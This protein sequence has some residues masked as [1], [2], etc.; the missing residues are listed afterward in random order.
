MK[1]KTILLIT[2]TAM[3]AATTRAQ[4]RWVK[5]DHDFGAFSEDIGAVD[6]VFEMVNDSPKAV[7]ILD[8]RATCGCTQPEIPRGD[9]AP[10]DTARIKVTYLASGRPGRFNK[11]IYVRTSDNPSEQK[12]LTVSGTVIGASATLASRFPVTA[13][14]LRLRTTTIAFGDVVRGKQKT[15]FV[16]GYNQSTDTLEPAVSGLPPYI[17]LSITPRRVAPGEQVQFGFTL[18]TLRNPQWGISSEKFSLCPDPALTDT[19]EMD[20]F[21]IINEDFSQLTP[22]Q[23]LNAPVATLDPARVNLG[24]L[25]AGSDPVK[26]EFQVKN[27]GRSP[28]MIRRVQVIDPAAGDLSVSTTKVKPGKSAKITLTINP[29]KARTDFINA[30]VTIITND[31]DNSLLAARITA[32]V[33]R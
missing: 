14:P 1:L 3:A 32:E 21:T 26:V 11:N 12:T 23:R 25:E 17:D 18:Q 33:K 31:P 6:A 5:A 27:T 8:A 10:G 9:I 28:L 7:R 13:G 24:E 2:L 16:E 20:F 30:R 29:A 4:V 15:V 19:A 22:G